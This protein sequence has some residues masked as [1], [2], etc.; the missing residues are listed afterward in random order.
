MRIELHHGEVLRLE[1]QVKRGFAEKRLQ[2]ATGGKFV[3]A[4]QKNRGRLCSFGDFLRSKHVLGILH[5]KSSFI[6]NLFSAKP[7]LT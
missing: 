3:V 2:N 4:G 1:F 6:L 5:G 7:R